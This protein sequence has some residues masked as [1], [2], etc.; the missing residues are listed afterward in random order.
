MGVF[1]DDLRRLAF[2]VLDE[3]QIGALRPFGRERAT[4][5]GDVL[6]RAG[7][8][9]YPLV[10]VIEGRTRI[11]DYSDG[12]AHVIEDGGPGEIHG[13]LA[14][15]TGQQ[16]FADCIVGESG[17]VLLVPPAGLREAIRTSSEL[18]DLL[19]AAFAARRQL[20]MRLSAASL[21]IVGSARSAAPLTLKEFLGRTRIPH[22]F[23]DRSDPLATT[24]LAPFGPQP[25]AATLAVVRG[26]R[27]L[28]DP[29][30]LDLA[31]ALGLDLV[32]D[33]TGPADLLVVGAGPAGLAAAVFG[34]SE[35]LTAVVV[36]DVAIGGQA[37]TSSRIEN[38]PGFPSGI[39][40]GELAFRTEVQAIK[41]GA[42]VTVPRRAVGLERRDGCF[43][44]AL[45][46]GKELLGRSVVVATGARYRRL[47]LPDQERFEGV[48]IYYA[49]TELEARFCRGIEVVVV[50]GG[51]SAGQA[52]LFL[53]RHARRVHLVYRG[54]GLASSMS[55][56]LIAR[57]EHTPNVAIRLDANLTGLHGGDRLDGVTL[58]PGGGSPERIAAPAVFAMIGAEPCTGWLDG[59]LSLDA[60]GFVPTG[61]EAHAGSSYETSQPGV[62]A[63][64]DVR[65][66]SFKRVASAVG[67]GSVVI[68]AVHRYLDAAG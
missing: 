59:T 65:S 49:A 5:A 34:A 23:I 3:A 60:N 48:G 7:D 8:A 41:F 50:G 63:V 33:Q 51:N 32:V 43:A 38:Y 57:L 37:G 1:S 2:P 45:D 35:G 20:F 21:T 28:V 13:E 53:S 40:G 11:L 61:P 17:R 58:T 67:E 42:R 12:A 56:Y 25:A 6:F 55:E 52:A 47:G 54:S 9:T 27:L 46:D 14:M 15:L 30:P 68:Q 16:A 39:S 4:A 19:V 22:R 29:R 64:G 10:V 26:T 31:K 66:G 36:D 24:V 18:S 44:V 62:F